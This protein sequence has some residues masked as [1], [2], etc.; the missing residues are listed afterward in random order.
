LELREKTANMTW[1]NLSG[2]AGEAD[3]FSQNQKRA[4]ENWRGNCFK[5]DEWISISIRV[6]DLSRKTKMWSEFPLS[7]SSEVT[8]Y[9]E[10]LCLSSY[11]KGLLSAIGRHSSD[12]SQFR[13]SYLIFDWRLVCIL[14]YPRY[15]VCTQFA[16]TVKKREGMEW[17]NRW[18]FRSIQ[19]FMN[20][21]S[22]WVWKS[23]F[24]SAIP[25]SEIQKV[26]GEYS[27]SK[28]S[29]DDDRGIMFQ[30]FDR[31]RSGLWQQLSLVAHDILNFST[32][33]NTRHLSIPFLNSARIFWGF[34]SDYSH[35][36]REHFKR[37]IW[38][39]KTQRGGR[40]KALLQYDW[41]LITRE[42]KIYDRA[43]NWHRQVRNAVVVL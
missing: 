23:T 39:G 30:R 15:S 31:S 26:K 42:I 40:L 25:R 14:E 34:Q 5:T 41:E 24:V 19:E 22:G 8:E 29:G 6:F 9:C 28:I 36:S 12:L 21:N 17:C 7:D 3:R 13:L 2:K 37:L 33:W 16:V 4:I 27:H 10:D 1:K 20:I 43:S 11:S 38:P 18:T 35:S 32:F